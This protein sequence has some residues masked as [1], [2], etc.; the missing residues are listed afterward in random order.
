MKFVVYCLDCDKEINELEDYDFMSLAQKGASMI[1]GCHASKEHCSHSL[2]FTIHGPKMQD[3]N[4]KRL[5]IECLHNNC[6][7]K[8]DKFIET[9]VPIELVSAITIAFHS[10]HEGHRLKLTYDGETWESPES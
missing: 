1:I 3:K 5:K 6:I 4:K 10:S 7:R 2:K 9:D 8:K